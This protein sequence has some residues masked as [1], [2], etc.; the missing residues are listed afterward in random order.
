MLNYRKPSSIITA[1]AALALMAGGVVWAADDMK[2]DAK[3]GDMTQCVMKETDKMKQMAA[4]PAEMSKM[5]DEM[6]KMMV[7]DKMAMKIA[8]DPQASE[9]LK[10]AMEDP[11][12]KKAHE[13]AMQMAKD[14]EQSKMMMDQIMADPTEMKSVM[15]SAMMMKMMEDKG[16][17]KMGEKMKG[18]GNMMN[19]A[20]DK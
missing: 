13:A 3:S 7:M 10:A 16:A 1:A 12:V 2:M 5:K 9:Q 14:P 19:K 20:E 15:H 4:D 6:A 11:N 17:G 18:M 8:N